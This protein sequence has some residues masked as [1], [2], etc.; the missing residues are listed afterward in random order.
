MQNESYTQELS[1][2]RCSLRGKSPWHCVVTYKNAETSKAMDIKI[3]I[4]IY[5]MN[6]S[7]I[8]MVSTKFRQETFY[9]EQKKCK[10]ILAGSQYYILLPKERT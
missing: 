9:H 8:K 6:M 1:A 5:Y 3:N 10:L 2:C 7:E 4:I